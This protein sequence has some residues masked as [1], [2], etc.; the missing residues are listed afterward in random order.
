MSET[1]AFVPFF[2]KECGHR[3]EVDS[4]LTDRDRSIMP[5]PIVCPS[6]MKSVEWLNEIEHKVR[7]PEHLDI[8]RR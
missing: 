2:C 6:C 3:I 1:R 4:Q 8:E 5:L 7:T